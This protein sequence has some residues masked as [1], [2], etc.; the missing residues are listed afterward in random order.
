MEEVPSASIYS[1]LLPPTSMEDGSFHS[2]IIITS[3]EVGGSFD[4]IKW[5]LPSQKTYSAKAC[6]RMIISDTCHINASYQVA[7]RGTPRS[8][9][10]K[11]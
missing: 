10:V 3:M 4:G 6:T 5:K 11:Q 9:I 1:H 2:R 7:Q 8:S